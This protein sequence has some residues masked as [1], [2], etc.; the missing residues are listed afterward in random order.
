MDL[1]K[2]KASDDVSLNHTEWDYKHNPKLLLQRLIRRRPQYNIEKA[3]GRGYWAIV[4]ANNK[5]F[6]HYGVTVDKATESAVR[7]AIDNILG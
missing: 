4:T 5:T 1:P 3:H 7:L 6:R 2:W